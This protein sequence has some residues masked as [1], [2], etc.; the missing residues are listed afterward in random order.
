MTISIRPL[1]YALGAEIGNVDL[2]SLD[3]AT[4][5]EIRQAFLDYHVI[6]FR[7]QSITRQDHIDLSKRF[8]EVYLQ[9]SQPLTYVDGPQDYPELTMVINQPSD[10]PPLRVAGGAWHSDRSHYARGAG[11][12][13]LRCVALPGVGGDTMFANMHK[14]YAE[15]SDG[16]KEIVEGLDGVYVA[17]DDRMLGKP[18]FDLSSPEAYWKSR[19]KNPSA[20]HSVVRTHEESGEK[21]LFIS[22]ETFQFVG[23]TEEESGPL[24]EYL[25]QQA[26]R[27]ENVY[28]HRW[29][30]NDLL[31]WDNRSVL[32]MALKDYDRGKLR[33]M[34]RVAV[35]A[36]E[37]GYE[38]FGPI[39]P[40]PAAV[41]PSEATVEPIGA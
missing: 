30:E 2:A 38:Y 37:S 18:P 7:G 10:N 14:A 19:L 36:A 13:L 8:G 12:S 31:I 11:A 15:L 41:D 24:I 3:D 29:Q 1:G 22:E 23:M 16:M 39:G 20:A 27:P 33:H 26:T 32:H 28:R 35:K 6:L 40:W 9:T 5:A 21:S 17:F 4:F 25:T 34:E